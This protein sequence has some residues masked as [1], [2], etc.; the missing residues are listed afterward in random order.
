MEKKTKKKESKIVEKKPDL[1]KKES[2]FKRGPE[3]FGKKNK[4]G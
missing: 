1:S 3:K 2:T 4:N